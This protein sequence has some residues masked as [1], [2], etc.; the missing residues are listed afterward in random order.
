MSVS[1]K[2]VGVSRKQMWCALSVLLDAE[3]AKAGAGH[4]PS[5]I[6]RDCVCI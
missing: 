5:P 3:R 1:R 2:Q 4:V 6:A